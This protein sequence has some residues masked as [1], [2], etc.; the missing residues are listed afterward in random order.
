MKA[1]VSM[2][3]GQLSKPFT[4]VFL[5]GKEFDIKALIQAGGFPSSHSSATVACATLL[6]LERGLSD[7]IF[8]LAVVY[9]GLV[10]YDAQEVG[11]GGSLAVVDDLCS[12]SGPKGE[13]PAKGTPMTKSV[14]A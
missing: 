9:A 2:A 4:S 13:V 7:P 12:G 3:I 5:Y 14:S 8:G 6:G 1:V 10:M 11:D